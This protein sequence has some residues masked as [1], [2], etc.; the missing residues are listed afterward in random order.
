MSEIATDPQGANQN[1][2]YI[3]LRPRAEWRTFHG[4]RMTKAELAQII[5]SV[6][7]RSVP[8]QELELNQPIAVRFDELLEGVRTDWPSNCSARTTI[9]W[10]RWRPGGGNRPEAA[11]GR[12]S[13][14]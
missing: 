2:I 10:T 12:R 9:N 14:D 3:S 1:D 7:E 13:G 6:I 5:R 11:G 4:H 8:G